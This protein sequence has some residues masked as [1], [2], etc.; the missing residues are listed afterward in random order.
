[1][2]EY[3]KELSAALDVP[4]DAIV[5]S[6]ITEAKAKLSSLLENASEVSDKLIRFSLAQKERAD[7]MMHY[8]EGSVL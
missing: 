1:L 2:S 6:N 3:A 7:R 4:E 8:I 5:A